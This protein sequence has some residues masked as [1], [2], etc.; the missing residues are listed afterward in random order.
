VPSRGS[1]AVSNVPLVVLF[2]ELVRRARF[3]PV[4]TV[5][6]EELEAVSDVADGTWFVQGF[7]SS[8]LYVNNLIPKMAITNYIHLETH[9]SSVGGI[10][11][12]WGPNSANNLSSNAE[13][14]N[15]RRSVL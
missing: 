2:E 4:E 5:G 13:D 7:Y 11:V 12:I 1:I 10:S 9:V 6:V 8:S 14:Y 15:M 3:S